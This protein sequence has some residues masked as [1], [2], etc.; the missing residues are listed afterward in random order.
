MKMSKNTRPALL[1][2]NVQIALLDPNHSFHDPAHAWFAKNRRYGW[3]TCPITENGCIRILGKVSYPAIGL[4]P[5]Q[6]RAI[7]ARFTQPDD[8]AFWPDSSTLLDACSP[9]NLE[10]L[11]A[12]S[13]LTTP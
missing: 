12:T 11:S 8:H 3:A 13:P 2:M 9:E 5:E 4:T 7:L 1:D 6:V 10:L